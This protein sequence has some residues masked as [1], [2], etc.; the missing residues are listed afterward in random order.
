MDGKQEDCAS[1]APAVAAATHRPAF[2]PNLSKRLGDIV[3]WF[4]LTCVI[5]SYIAV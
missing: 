4:D 3:V 1:L 5:R 2:R